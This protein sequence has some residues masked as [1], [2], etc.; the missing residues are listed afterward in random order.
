MNKAEFLDI[1][2][3]VNHV[4]LVIISQ[5]LMLKSMNVVL[6]KCVLLFLLSNLTFKGYKRK[7]D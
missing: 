3:D 4:M 1:D 2:G 5:I 7:K 6:E